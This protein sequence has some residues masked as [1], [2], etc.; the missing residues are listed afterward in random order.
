MTSSF[1]T[2]DGRSRFSLKLQIIKVS[3]ETRIRDKLC[4]GKDIVQHFRFDFKYT[5]FLF[6]ALSLIGSE[7]FIGNLPHIPCDCSTL[8]LTVNI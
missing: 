1:E 5:H 7:T 4:R 8:R 3:L 6:P 2:K